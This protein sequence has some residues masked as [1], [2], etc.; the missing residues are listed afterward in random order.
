[1]D[2]ASLSQP[3]LER[4]DTGCSARKTELPKDSTLGRYSFS[5]KIE[6][7]LSLGLIQVFDDGRNTYLKFLPNTSSN[8]QIRDGG[9]NPLRAKQEGGFVTVSGVHERLT[10]KE[11]EKGE[12]IIRR[13]HETSPLPLY[14]PKIRDDAL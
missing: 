8:P 9:N 12:A 4:T 6:N 1:M 2:P 13:I 11:K 10:I 14:A 7:Q 5:Y 3:G